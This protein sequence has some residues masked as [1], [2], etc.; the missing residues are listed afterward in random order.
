MG[1]SKTVYLG[2]G[3]AEWLEKKPTG[4]INSIISSA[5][6]YEAEREE[7]AEKAKEEAKGDAEMDERMAWG[8]WVRFQDLKFSEICCVIKELDIPS[9]FMFQ[10]SWEERLRMIRFAEE[11][12]IFHRHD[13]EEEERK[14]AMC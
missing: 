8:K 6:K 1:K 14:K 5:M 7:M 9:R 2:D 3:K 10:Y 13:Q 12:G 4:H 11:K